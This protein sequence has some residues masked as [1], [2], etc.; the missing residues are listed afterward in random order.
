MYV[1]KVARVVRKGTEPKVKL[2]SA[3][4]F[5]MLISI[6]TSEFLK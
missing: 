3:H 6:P 5:A 4:S 1:M 2:T